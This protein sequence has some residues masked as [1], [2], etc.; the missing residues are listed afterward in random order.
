MWVFTADAGDP[1]QP[2]DC[3]YYLSQAEAQAALD[4]VLAGAPETNPRNLREE[5]DDYIPI[6]ER[7]ATPQLFPNGETRYSQLQPR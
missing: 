4:S 1:P 2:R 5:P 7:L 6:E 3:R